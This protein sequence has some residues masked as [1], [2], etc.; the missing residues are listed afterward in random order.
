MT[1]VR[2]QRTHTI[3]VSGTELEV[4]TAIEALRRHDQLVGHPVGR[5][6]GDRIVVD[7]TVLGR[8]Q[9]SRVLRRPASLRWRKPAAAYGGVIGVV[10]AVA[11]VLGASGALDVLLRSLIG[12]VGAMVL[13]WLAWV[14]GTVAHTRHCPG[15]GHH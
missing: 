3:E 7:V 12:A 9:R 11:H 2:E 14:V 4:R 8:P 5:R 6:E 15:C 10:G 1:S 13:S